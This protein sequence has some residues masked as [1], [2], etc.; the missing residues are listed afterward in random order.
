MGLGLE[1]RGT[2]RPTA[3]LPHTPRTSSPALAPH[4]SV[5]SFPQPMRP[6][7][8]LTALPRQGV[9]PEP[10]LRCCVDVYPGALLS[11]S[12]PEHP[13]ASTAAPFLPSNLVGC[14][15]SKSNDALNLTGICRDSFSLLI[16]FNLALIFPIKER[17]NFMSPLPAGHEGNQRGSQGRW[18]HGRAR[19]A[20]AACSFAPRNSHPSHTTQDHLHSP[21][22]LPS[23][24]ETP[25]ISLQAACWRQFS[26]WDPFSQMCLGLS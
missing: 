23:N 12:G 13:A 9:G 3:L 8:A 19:G 6:G 1:G 10:Q 4:A 7:S 17:L 18:R 14:F 5:A 22:A 2:R 16:Y 24:R 15:Q 20:L 26:N 21:S 11:E 25:Q